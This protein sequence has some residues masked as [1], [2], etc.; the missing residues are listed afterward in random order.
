MWSFLSYIRSNSDLSSLFE[1]VSTSLPPFHALQIVTMRNS[2]IDRW[3][4]TSYLRDYEDQVLPDYDPSQGTRLFG[5]MPNSWL[6]SVTCLTGSTH[7]NF[8]DGLMKALGGAANSRT[9]VRSTRPSS[10]RSNQ[11][12]PCLL[13]PSL[14]HVCI[15]ILCQY[16]TWYPMSYTI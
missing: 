16:T 10:P 14:T 11:G 15:T 3:M 8:Q 5:L 4:R 7:F 13:C 1:W 2:R 6:T 12:N 9:R